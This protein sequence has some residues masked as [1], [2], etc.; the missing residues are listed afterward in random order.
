M[1][2]VLR[3]YSIAVL[4]ICT[5]NLI[6]HLCLYPYLPKMIPY[7]WNL[8]G[9]VNRTGPKEFIFI[10]SFLPFLICF[11]FL[12]RPKLDPKHESYRKHAKAYSIFMLI[13]ISFM[14]LVS[15]MVLFAGLGYSIRVDIVIGVLL[16]LLFIFLGNYMAQIRPNFF[17]GI[18]T[19]W[20]LSSE[21]NWR[22]THRLGAPL[23][24]GAGLLMIIGAFFYKYVLL[25]C[26]ILILIVSLVLYLYSYLLYRKETNK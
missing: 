26:I 6:V 4:I 18:R 13:V 10:T 16:G 7:H 20:T 17:V 2:Y 1:K 23:F 14:S 5:I 11:L 3:G 9:Q 21:Q 24:A 25:G 19:P 12:I 22:K 8:A 15:I